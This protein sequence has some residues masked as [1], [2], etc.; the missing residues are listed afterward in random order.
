MKAREQVLT[1]VHVEDEPQHQLA[2]KRILSY[3][4]RFKLIAELTSG[5]HALKICPETRPDF[6]IVD[7]NFLD[8]SGVECASQLIKLC[9]TS[10]IISTSVSND[11]QIEQEM[12]L[13]GVRYFMSKPFVDMGVID[14]LINIDKT[15]RQS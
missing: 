7:T 12:L 8:M 13:A 2:L 11:P 9:P 4:A 1:V 15:R 3:D 6:I 5:Q 10:A 14:T